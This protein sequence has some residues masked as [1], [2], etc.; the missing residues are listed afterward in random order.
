[1]AMR[2]SR[3]GPDGITEYSDSKELLESRTALDEQ[4]HLAGCFAVVG[5]ILGALA[6]FVL[7]HFHAKSLP[8]IVRFALV[9]VAGFASAALLA[10]SAT[11]IVRVLLFALG[12][13]VLTG[14]GA[15]IWKAL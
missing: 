13:T 7:L 3:R 14:I 5:L 6:T 8:K 9:I 15:L 2:Y 10:K 11:W 12:L 4:E 1:M